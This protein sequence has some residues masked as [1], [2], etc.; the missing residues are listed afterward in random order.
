MESEVFLELTDYTSRS[1][2]TIVVPS[3]GICGELL[4]LYA[5][6]EPR[7]LISRVVI[8][9]ALTPILLVAFFGTDL[10]A[11]INIPLQSL[12]AGTWPGI[13]C[14]NLSFYDTGHVLYPLAC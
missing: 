12:I 4:P 2:V 11:F 3:N 7:S 14:I 8:L 1:D 6:I 10:L 5:I 9:W 13:F